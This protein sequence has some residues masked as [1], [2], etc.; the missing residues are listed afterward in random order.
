MW[1]CVAVREFTF[2]SSN[3]L[4]HTNATNHFVFFL[5][6]LFWWC[7]FF[8]GASFFVI[9][10]FDFF[11]EFV[12]L[13]LYSISLNLC[14]WNSWVCLYGF[15]FLTLVA[16]PN[17][18]NPMVNHT[19]T[20]ARTHTHTHKH[21]N[22]LDSFSMPQFCTAQIHEMLMHLIPNDPKKCLVRFPFE[23]DLALLSFAGLAIFYFQRNKKTLLCVEFG[24]KLAWTWTKFEGEIF[25][26]NFIFITLFS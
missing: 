25:V 14:V 7:F 17:L 4:I 18:V 9:F 12:R 22:S 20:N 19:K 2:P 26:T 3:F 8:D 16:L 21:W 23:L 1:I 5:V 13:L 10:L 15:S 24:V 6:C 11:S